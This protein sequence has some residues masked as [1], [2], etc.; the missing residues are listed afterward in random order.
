[1]PS[2]VEFLGQGWDDL[3]K[4]THNPV[5]GDVEDRG[6][7]IGIDGYDALSI[8]HPHNVLN[9]SG[10]TAS[11]IEARR[12]RLPLAADLA[13]PAQPLTIDN[14]T[15]GCNLRPESFR[16]LLDNLQ[17]FRF[18]DAAPHRHNQFRL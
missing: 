1:M 3:E 5:G 15:T 8:L 10:D 14:G 17:I 18:L 7:G 13:V 11:Q 4:V 9:R 12:D 16:Q 2:F 6:I